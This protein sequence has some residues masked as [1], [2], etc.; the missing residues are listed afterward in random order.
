MKDEDYEQWKRDIQEWRVSEGEHI[1]FKD[2][3]EWLKILERFAKD[4]G[5][6]DD[7]WALEV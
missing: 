2:D 3:S 1:S 6:K 4:R 7:K 5:D